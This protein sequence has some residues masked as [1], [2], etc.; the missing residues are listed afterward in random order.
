[1]IHIAALLMLLAQH[2]HAADNTIRRHI[3]ELN[4]YIQKQDTY[5]AQKEERIAFIKSG[6]QSPGLSLQEMYTRSQLLYEEYSTYQYDSMY[7]YA[8][9]MLD[10][11]QQISNKDLTVKSQLAI[12]NTFMWGGLFKDAA[13]YLNRI[14]TTGINTQTQVEYW[15]TTFSITFESALYARYNDILF[16]IYKDQ[17]ENIIRKI[18]QIAPDNHE[19]INDKKL[20]LAFHNTESAKSLQ[21]SLAL[22]E[23]VTPRDSISSFYSELL[24]GIGYNYIDSG[25]TIRGMKYMTQSAILAIKQGSY[26]YSAMRRIAEVTYALGQLQDAYKY[27]QL[28]MANAKFFGSRY[29]IYE[30]SKILPRVD[31]DLNNMLQRQ[32]AEIT[33]LLFIVTLGAIALLVVILLYIKRNTKLKATKKRLDARNAQLTERNDE[34]RKM[35]NQLS[36]ANKMKEAGIALLFNSN[37]EVHSKLEAFRKSVLRRIKAKQTDALED[38]VN[39]SEVFETRDK[40]LENFDAMFLQLFP[41]FVNSLNAL[42]LPACRITVADKDSLTPELR[43]FALIRLGINK[44]E[45]I[46]RYLNYSVSTVKNYKTKI[47]NNSIVD[48]EEFEERLM[49]IS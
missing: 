33:N 32:K 28:S 3:E 21:Y 18:E 8:E 27:I 22:K 49:Q 36:E 39:T 14:D 47:K 41:D 26:R 10:L 40:V 37:I 30:A 4:T 2:T 11:A 12:A 13:E 1:M 23:Q 29:R 43:I 16:P 42:L 25:D 5:R 45:T 17:M 20:K 24:G 19:L 44:N 15:S 38:L 31:A 48:N 34:I 46:A 7:V 6:L 9:R 35:I